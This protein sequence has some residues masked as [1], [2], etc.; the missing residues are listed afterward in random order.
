MRGAWRAVVAAV[1]VVATAAVVAACGARGGPQDAVED[2]I[3]AARRA[4]RAAVYRRLGPA[5]RARLAALLGSPGKAA[6]PAVTDPADLLSVGWAPP[7]WERAGMR[8]LHQAGDRA[9][10]EVYS[11]SGE[12]HAV[13]LVREDGV[14][15]V[16]LPGT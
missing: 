10:V 13:T 9:E 1:A 12:R 4:D 2:V 3:A 11:A 15:K 6:G 16:E 8:T 7:S 14:W 5:T